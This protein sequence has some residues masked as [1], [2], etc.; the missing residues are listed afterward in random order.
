MTFFLNVDSIATPFILHVVAGV[1]L[2]TLLQDKDMFSFQGV[3][4]LRLKDVI[5]AGTGITGYSFYFSEIK[6]QHCTP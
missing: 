6:S 1:G 4:R 3:T 2:P 5:L